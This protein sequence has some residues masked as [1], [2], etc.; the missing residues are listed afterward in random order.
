[1]G[2]YTSQNDGSQLEMGGREKED[3]SSGPGS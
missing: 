3:R 2:I 1:V